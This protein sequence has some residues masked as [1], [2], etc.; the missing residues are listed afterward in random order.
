MFVLTALALGIAT[1]TQVSPVQKVITLLDDLKSKVEGELANEE[2]LMQEFTKWCDSEANE[3]EDN[4][5]SADRTAED[6][7]ATIE[8]MTGTITDLESDVSELAASSAAG[9]RDVA[10]ATKIREQERADFESTEKE[11]T[12]TVDTLER[13]IIVLKRGQTSFM[14]SKTMPKDFSLLVSG[15]SKIVEATWV[16]S[17]QRSAVQALIQSKDGSEDEDLTLQPQATAAAYASKGGGILDVL[18]DMQDKAEKALSDSRKTEMEQNHAFEMLKQGLQSQLATEGKRLSDAQAAKTE[19]QEAYHTAEGELLAARK[20]SKEDATYLTTLKA[21]CAA[22][23]GEW[24]ERQQ[25]ASDELT[26]IAKARELLSDNKAFLQ[27][28]AKDPASS[29]ER[30]EQL[31]AVLSSLAEKTKKFSLQ[32]LATSA[33]ADP[34][35]KVKE[36]IEAMIA[37][38]LESAA[39]ESDAKSFCD[40]ETAK[41]RAKQAELSAKLDMHAR[42]IE[43]GAAGKA[44]LAQEVKD[45]DAE[46]ASID[47]GQAEATKIRQDEH[48]QYTTSTTEWKAS[49]T[50]IANAMEVLQRYYAGSFVQMKTARRVAEL[51]AP[52]PSFGSSKGDAA[53]GILGLLEVA[54]SD[55][56][57]M[58]TEAEAQETGAQR[59]HEELAQENRVTKAAKLAEAQAKRGE[60]KTLEVQLLNYKEDHS[61]VAKELDAVMAYLDKL[62]PQCETK[63]MSFA[64]RTA[65][66]EQ[67]IEGLKE[68]LQILGAE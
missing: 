21:S 64:E 20:S 50:A 6:K 26:A 46:I 10:A 3:K 5:R 14:Q 67:E 57:R 37:R 61:F 15:L 1:S 16:N 63:V 52:S 4:I 17:Q 23:A 59:A 18:A 13:A 25:S 29:E 39:E 42:R 66:R 65:R 56:T 31:V 43:K 32:Q 33:A 49:A 38:L 58:I 36:M 62:K 12:E 54:E 47:A 51:R 35:G 55:L 30:R 53:S 9:D 22:K 7:Q 44:M 40:T 45:L 2:T 34:F 24:S 41:S 68:A 19:A 48:A 60:I 11:M 27:V 28:R 8:D